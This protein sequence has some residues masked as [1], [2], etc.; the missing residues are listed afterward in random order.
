MRRTRRLAP[1][2]IEAAHAIVAACGRALAAGG[3]RNWD[4]P[5]PLE[6]MRAEATS[7]QIYLV[8][9][10]DEAVATYTVT[11]TPPHDYPPA[12]FAP[13]VPALYLNR[14]AVVPARQKSGLGRACMADVEAHARAAAC[15]VVRFDVFRDN[16]VIR[17][18]YQRL[19]YTE[20]GPFFVGEIPVICCEKELA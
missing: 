12:I 13:A 19:G 14:L 5:Y 1:G 18:F 11:T 2:E 7:R 10:G 16:A 3:W 17:A 15:R 8:T 9:D 4:P 20:L 6:R